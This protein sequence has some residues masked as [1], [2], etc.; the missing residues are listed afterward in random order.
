VPAAERETGGVAVDVVGAGELAGRDARGFEPADPTELGEVV[1]NRESPS[2]L[3]FRGR[4]VAGIEPRSLTVTVVRY[5]P[6][7]VLVANVEEARYRTLISEDGRLLVE[8][9]Y[10]VRNNQ[11]SFVKV[12]LPP[13][14]IVWSAEVSGRPIRPGAVEHDAVLLPLEKRRAGEEG[15]AFVVSIVYLQTVDPWTERGRTRIDLPT[16]DLPVSRREW[17]CIT[18]RGS[19]WSRSSARS[20]SRLIWVLCRGRQASSEASLS[21]RARRTSPSPQGSRHLSI[22][23]GIKREGEPLLARCQYM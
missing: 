6:Q 4:P 7:A 5:T 9:R 15:P 20:A 2:M 17:S 1:A 8:A 3:A 21:P 18:R 10:S 22:A 23:I 16:L 12:T 11:R 13:Q 19:V 14:S